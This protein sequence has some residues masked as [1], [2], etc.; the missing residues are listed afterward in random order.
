MVTVPACLKCNSSYQKDDVGFAIAT[1]MEAYIEHPQALIA[2]EVSLRP[3][4]LRNP[5]LRKMLTSNVLPGQPRTPAGIYLPDR[6]AILFPKDRII[7]VIKRIV[8]GLLWEHYRQK[9]ATDTEIE[10]HRNPKLLPELAEMINTLTTFSWIGD[11]IFR[12]RHALTHDDPDTSLWAMQ[13]YGQSQ[14][15]VIVE[16]QSF[17]NAEA[18]SGPSRQ[19]ICS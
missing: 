8:R 19:T 13:F 11:D 9:I 3:M 10:V 16:G 4:I 15:I 12:Y 14:Y 2:W 5:L 1:C 6:T 17:K 7:R 18:N